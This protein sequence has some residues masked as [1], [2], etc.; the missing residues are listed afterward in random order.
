MEIKLK[1]AEVASHPDHD[2]TEATGYTVQLVCVVERL[3][4]EVPHLK[5]TAEQFERYH[6]LAQLFNRHTEALAVVTI[7]SPGGTVL[8]RVIVDDYNTSHLM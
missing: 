1:T 2:E 4:T 8:K 6:K 7:T 3:V 5:D